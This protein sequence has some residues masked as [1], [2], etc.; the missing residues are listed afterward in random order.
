MS[1]KRSPSC[2][3][4]QR[5]RKL[6]SRSVEGRCTS[7]LWGMDT[8]ST[9]SSAINARSR[10]SLS[11]MVSSSVGAS[12]AITALTKSL[13]KLMP[14]SRTRSL[15]SLKMRTSSPVLRSAVFMRDLYAEAMSGT[16]TTT[17][18]TTRLLQDSRQPAA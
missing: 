4:Q 5:T 18:E 7:T 1:W 6:F 16:S 9:S 3:P 14:A 12:M 11:G 10:R 13:V 15:A 2:L 8:N 17:S